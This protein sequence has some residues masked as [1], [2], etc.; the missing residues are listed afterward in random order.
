[1]ENTFETVK[2]EA[3]AFSLRFGG[4]VHCIIVHTSE[5]DAKPLIKQTS[6]LHT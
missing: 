3:I 4:F 1:M 6:R 5:Q 2:Y